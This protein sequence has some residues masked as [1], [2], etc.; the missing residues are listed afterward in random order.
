MNKP[1]HISEAGFDT[2]VLESPVPVLVNLWVPCCGL[3]RRLSRILNEIAR[4]QGGGSS[5]GF[6]I[7]KVNAE[8]H[9]ALAQRLGV[10]SR[11]GERGAGGSNNIGADPG[12]PAM[13]FF[14]AGRLRHAVAGLASKHAILRWLHAPATVCANS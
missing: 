6:R 8:E 2:A 14:H 10:Q 13:L 3:C 1:L 11:T 5:D 12:L 9:P 4:E 7:V